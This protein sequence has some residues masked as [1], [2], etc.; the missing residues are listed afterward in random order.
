MDIILA[1]ASPRR[2]ELLKNIFA[3]KRPFH[4]SREYSCMVVIIGLRKMYLI[5]R[6]IRCGVMLVL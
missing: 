6:A 2:Q 5:Y 4:P 1:S 3:A